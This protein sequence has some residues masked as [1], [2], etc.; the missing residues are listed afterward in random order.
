MNNFIKEQAME[1]AHVHY[2]IGKSYNKKH[3]LS[4][5]PNPFNDNVPEYDGFA[6]NYNLTPQAEKLKD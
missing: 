1:R 6:M 5:P 3:M 4:E 2:I